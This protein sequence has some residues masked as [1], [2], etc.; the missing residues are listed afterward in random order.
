MY[1]FLLCSFNANFLLHSFYTFF[2]FFLFISKNLGKT[3][4]HTKSRKRCIFTRFPSPVI[5]PSVCIRCMRWRRSRR[6]RCRRGRRASPPPPPPTT[7]PPASSSQH[8]DFDYR[9]VHF[10]G[11]QIL[12]QVQLS[13]CDELGKLGDSSGRGTAPS[14]NTRRRADAPRGE[15]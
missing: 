6:R 11:C 8:F 7:T 1:T 14:P 10:P 5:C 2:Y 3:A 13:T 15:D 4:Y 9:I 12:N